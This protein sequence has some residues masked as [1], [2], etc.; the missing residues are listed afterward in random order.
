MSKSVSYLVRALA[1]AS[2]LT[3]ASVAVADDSK[4]LPAAP[5]AT[6]V[7]IQK[8]TWGLTYPGGVGT[9]RVTVSSTG[10]FRAG[11]VWAQAISPGAPT[12]QGPIGGVFKPGASAL[13]QV[14]GTG[15]GRCYNIVLA[16]EPDSS[17][18]GVRLD[19]K[20]SSRRVCLDPDG[21]GIYN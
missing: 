7:S 17:G 10:T 13:G 11:A 21:A 1:V 14:P 18:S 12:V 4:L 9:F 5:P 19:P 15:N 6:V 8:V 20:N 16:I 2:V 3:V